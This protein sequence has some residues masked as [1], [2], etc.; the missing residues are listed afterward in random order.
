MRK[1]RFGLLALALSI[2]TTACN[3]TIT[4]PDAENT[5]AL[6]SGG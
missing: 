1:L 5:G 4:A 3:G 6:G 2:V